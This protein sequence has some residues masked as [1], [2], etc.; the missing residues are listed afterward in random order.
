VQGYLS[1]MKVQGESLLPTL[2][3]TFLGQLPL[4]QILA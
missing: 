2:V 3:E 4:P 1:T